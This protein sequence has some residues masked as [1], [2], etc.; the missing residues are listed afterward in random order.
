M[1][2]VYRATIT[3]SGSSRG[4]VNFWSDLK[5]TAHCS[6]QKTFLKENV[7]LLAL[8]QVVNRNKS[9]KTAAQ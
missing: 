5:T 2:Q 6:L 8:I 9:K 7:W 3:G 4:S 1:H